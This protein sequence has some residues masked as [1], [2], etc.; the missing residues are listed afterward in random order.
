[1]IDEASD[2]TLKEELNQ[3]T[4]E[5]NIEALQKDGALKYSCPEYTPS[6]RRFLPGEEYH[7]RSQDDFH[8][9]EFRPEEFTITSTAFDAIRDQLLALKLIKKTGRKNIFHLGNF[10]TLTPHGLTQMAELRAIR[11]TDK[12]P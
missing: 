5:A 12:S 4:G 10:W 9:Q 11:K 1:M 3:M 8:P 7:P 2:S 6:L